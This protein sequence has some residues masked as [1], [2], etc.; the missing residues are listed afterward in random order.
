MSFS[1]F[2]CRGV[3]AVLLSGLAFAAPAAA[4]D[5][6]E[7]DCENAMTQFDMNVCSQQ[8]YEKADKE[9]NAQW[10]KTKKV[11]A[12]WDAE[13]DAENKGAVESLVGAQRAW[14]QYRDNQCDAVGY[15]VWG[16]S[17]YPMIVS[18]CLADLTRKRT[19]ELKSMVEN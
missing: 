1:I 18:S 13:L 19:E 6:P 5:E 12:D 9:L 15:S 16:G 8:D 11:M 2:S 3:A 17:M 10:A 7:V 4:E 14:I